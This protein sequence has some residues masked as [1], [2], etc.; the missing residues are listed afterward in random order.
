VYNPDQLDSESDDVGDVCDNCVAVVNSDQEDLDEDGIGDACD[1]CTDTDDDGYGDP[2]FP[3]N[4]CD[5]DNCPLW[6]NPGQ[7]DEDE[8]GLGDVCD[9]LCG[10]VDGSGTLYPDVTDVIYYLTWMFN[11]GPPPLEMRS[12]NTGGCAGVDITDLIALYEHVE[13]QG[14]ELRCWHN[15]A[16]PPL[17]DSGSVSIDHVDGLWSADTVATGVPITFHLRMTNLSS[18]RIPGMTNGFRVYSPTGATWDTTVIEKIYF[19]PHQTFNWVSLFSS[20]S[21]TGSGADTVAL[22]A[23]TP[24]GRGLRAGFDE[25]THAITIGPIDTSYSGG[26]ICIDSCWFGPTN[27]WLWAT[28]QRIPAVPTWTGP[29]CFTIANCCQIRGDVDRNGTGPDIADLIYMVTYMFQ[30]GP[31]PL[32]MAE[33]DVDGIGGATPDITDLVYLVTYMFQGGPDLVP[34]P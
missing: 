22:C 10:D 3:L 18:G 29:H 31:V 6:F 2:G 14:T 15:E 25:I 8:D 30:D 24:T 20:S 9:G 26:E 19:L 33:T 13:G 1:E 17:Q 12:A 32:C 11:G 16:C 23:A 5:E 7:E 4:T 27:E 34:C 21:V 28:V